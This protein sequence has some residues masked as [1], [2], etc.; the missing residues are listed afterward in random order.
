MQDTMKP[1]VGIH[2]MAIVGEKTIYLSHLPMWMAPHNFQVILQA[3]FHG[4]N[5]PQERYV[6]DRQATGTKLYTLQPSEAFALEDLVPVSPQDSPLRTSFRAV[7]W[8]NHFEN[9]PQTHPG[10]R[11]KIGEADVHVEQ[12]VYFRRLPFQRPP[13][14]NI[15]YVPFGQGEE[16]FAAHLITTPPDFDQIVSLQIENQPASENEKLS[17]IPITLIGRADTISEKLKEGER[18]QGTLRRGTRGEHTLQ[19]TTGTE[20]YFE[21]ED[22]EAPVA[23]G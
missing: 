20:W 3:T 6:K 1:P 11:L 19:F 17:G 14:W 8:R 10:K 13:Q 18:L 4:E 7:I 9:H 5:D 16:L 2:G 12:V 21:T 23:I 15:T 22:L